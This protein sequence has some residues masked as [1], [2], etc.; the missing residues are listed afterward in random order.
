MEGG[1]KSDVEP[2]ELDQVN[3]DFKD[4]IDD[5]D[6]EADIVIDEVDD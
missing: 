4:I 1:S 2:T 6:R 3:L 5:S